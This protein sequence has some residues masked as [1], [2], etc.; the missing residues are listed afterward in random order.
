MSQQRQLEN[1]LI[2]T[3]LGLQY[4]YTQRCLRRI[5]PVVRRHERA[6]RYSIDL[7]NFIA[8]GTLHVRHRHRDINDVT[9]CGGGVDRLQI[10]V[11]EARIGQAVAELIRGGVILAVRRA[12]GG[13]YTGTQ[14]GTRHRRGRESSLGQNTTSGVG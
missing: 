11:C 6:G 1:S 3:S 2:F 8:R 4:R 14:T 7:H 9:R 5:T 12:I 10:W 13:P